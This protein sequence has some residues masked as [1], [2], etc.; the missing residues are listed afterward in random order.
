MD[1]HRFLFLMGAMLDCTDPEATMPVQELA[2][3]RMREKALA[4]SKKR[5]I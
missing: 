3:L 2:T 4:A 5:G 1:V